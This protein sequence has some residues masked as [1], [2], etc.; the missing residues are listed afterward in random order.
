MNFDKLQL[1]TIL[2][3]RWKCGLNATEIHKEMKSAM[4]DE[5]LS[6]RT[7]QSWVQKFEA[8]DFD[9]SDGSK[10]GRPSNDYLDQQ[11]S[12]L[13]VENKHA[14]CREMATILNVGSMTV[15]RHLHNMDKRYLKFRWVPH[16][17]TDENCNNR[18]LI[19]NQLLVMHS[20]NNFLKQLITVDEVW[21][22]WENVAKTPGQHH[23]SWRGSGD[24]IPQVVQ[25]SHMTTKNI[26]V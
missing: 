26:S 16:Q 6:L 10:P 11:I 3:Y 8:G 23:R 5:Q 15:C 22:Y 17:L 19:C 25:R 12:D 7:C 18:V 1:R 2:Y 14:T 20:H 4:G 13:L 21:L 9:L 24:E